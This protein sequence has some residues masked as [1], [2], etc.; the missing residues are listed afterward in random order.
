MTSK[1]NNHLR[2][3]FLDSWLQNVSEGSGTAAAIG[4]LALA[5]E[6]KGH[7]IERIVP[8]SNN[9]PNLTLRRLWY[10]VTL[11][12]RLSDHS[13]DLIVGFDIDGIRWANQCNVPYV[14]CILGVL[15]EEQRFE[16]GWTKLLLWSLSR[17]E[18]LTVR[19]APCVISISQYCC[20]RIHANYGVEPQKMKVVPSGI[21]LSDW[22]I[23]DPNERDPWTVLCVARQ[24]PR[25]RVIDL[26]DAFKLVVDKCPQAKL[27][28]IGD[29]PE[30]AKICQRV[31]E[32][33]LSEQV[34]VLG[35]LADNED[36]RAWYRKSSVFCLPS[37]QEGFGIV[38]LE[39]MASGLP[40]IST[41]AT[42]IPEVVP[43]E[44]AGLLVQPRNPSALADAIITLLQNP[45][46][47][48]Q[49]RDFGLNYVQDFDWA[50]VAD[51]FLDTI[52][53]HFS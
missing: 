44:K 15:A 51:R 36:V 39:A 52:D 8:L 14:C 47:R 50:K 7:T 25:K 18:R 19:R 38:F 37:A 17:L 35:A 6:K 4:G 11:P 21:N 1:L 12:K 32:K 22:P 45:E 28:I 24:Y 53:Q 20:D 40:V 29:G 49:Y 33:K 2:I 27:V 48:S 9:P 23:T 5:L 34:Q 3:A 30:H 41:N 43:H 16:R 31:E 26:V 13:F 10:N 42:A 46:L